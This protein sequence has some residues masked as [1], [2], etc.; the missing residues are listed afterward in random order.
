MKSTK[1]FIKMLAVFLT[2]V[3]PA[4]T[5]ANPGCIKNTSIAASSIQTVFNPNASSPIVSGV[6]SAEAVA[7]SAISGVV[8]TSVIVS[9][10][11]IKV[12]A[13]TASCAKALVAKQQKMNIAVAIHSFVKLCLLYV[14]SIMIILFNTCFYYVIIRK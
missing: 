1:F 3:K 9:V 7:V 12:S 6:V 4:S 11:V 13:S 2:L 10:V 14:L 5:N 8:L